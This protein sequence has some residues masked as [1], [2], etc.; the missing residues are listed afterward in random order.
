M[1]PK[2]HRI[3]IE[4]VRDID[5]SIVWQYPSCSCQWSGR[6][7]TDPALAVVEGNRHRVFAGAAP[8]TPRVDELGGGELRAACSCEWRGPIRVDRDAA[9]ADGRQHVTDAALALAARNASDPQKVEG[10]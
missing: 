2:L 3:T 5:G 8:H 10:P 6:C 9:I 1:K 4:T 7:V